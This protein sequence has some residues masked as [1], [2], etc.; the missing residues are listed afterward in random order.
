M[1]DPEVRIDEDVK[2]KVFEDVKRVVREVKERIFPVHGL[3]A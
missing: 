3:E 2:R 1:V